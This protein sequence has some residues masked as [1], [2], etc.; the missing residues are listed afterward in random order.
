MEAKRG[1][2]A[3]AER[4]LI[5]LGA[6]LSHKGFFYLVDS[7]VNND[8]FNRRMTAVC[9][10]IAEHNNTTYVSVQRDIR[11][12]LLYMIRNGWISN[13]NEIMGIKVAGGTNLHVKEFVALC[14]EYINRL[15]AN[16]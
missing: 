10:Y 11:T 5:S 7:I 13:L 9:N 4:L 1:K 16:M 8:L 12:A 14:S 3:E 6:R 2:E 15:E